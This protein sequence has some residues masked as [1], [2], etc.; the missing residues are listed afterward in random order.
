MTYQVFGD[1]DRT[2]RRVAARNEPLS[3]FLDR[4]VGAYWGRTR[5][6]IELW[7]SRVSDSQR[8]SIASR[9]RS[10]DD[11]HFLAAF[12]ELY[13]HETLLSLG[14]NIT[15]EPVIPGRTRQ[16]DYLATGESGSVYVEATTVGGSAAEVARQRRIASLLDVIDQI[17]IADFL[18]D[19]EVESSGPDAPPTGEFRRQIAQ[20]L[21][22][23]DPDQIREGMTTDGIS[24]GPSTPAFLW[25]EGAWRVQVRPWPLKP[26]SRGVPGFRVIGS[27][28]VTEGSG[29]MDNTTPLRRALEDK[30]SAY[31]D[32][33]RPF[34]VAVGTD[35]ITSGDFDVTNALYGH[36][37]V[38]YRRFED[39]RVE[40]ES[41]R[42]ADGA[43]I[44]PAGWR[45]QRVSA[46]LHTRMLRPWLVTQTVPTLWIHPA[47]A[48][49]HACESGPWSIARLSPEGEL[50]YQQPSVGLPEFFE[51]PEDWPG[52]ERPFDEGS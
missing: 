31:G 14:S 21:D 44:G 33:G 6:L 39:G 26:E 30:A 42:A 13:C 4:A 3:M 18:L 19:I 7:V 41:T 27:S 34:V 40:T 35:A 10:R 48:H 20:W 23:L 32:L 17:P 8:A 1:F 28:S 37:Q 24:F 36:A 5:D 45:G 43:W 22:G 52:P 51:L 16:P 29:F 46:L 25:R 47:A 9:L 49:P 11:A 50:A 2:D 15:Y 12:F 38:T